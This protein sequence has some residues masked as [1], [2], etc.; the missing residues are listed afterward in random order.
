MNNLA[1]LY[2]YGKGIP[3][4]YAEAMRLFERGAALGEPSAMNRIGAMY[5]DGNGVRRDARLARQWFEK[6]AT[7]GDPEAKQNLKEMRR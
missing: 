4:D 2:L 1:R 3:R 7:L 5:N 6:A